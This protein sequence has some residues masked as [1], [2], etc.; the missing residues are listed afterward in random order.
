MDLRTTTIDIGTTRPLIL[1]HS[2]DAAELS[3]HPLDRVRIRGQRG[4]T[5]GIVKLT[6]ELVD[7]GEVGLTDPLHHLHGEVSVTLA[8]TPRSVQ[9]ITAKLA[10]VELDRAELEAIVQDIHE[11]RLSD[12]ELGAYV[13]AIAAN[14]LSLQETKHLTEAMSAVGKQL[15]WD[16]PI[17]ADKHSIGGVAGN[18][19]TPIVVS[20]VTAAGVTMPKTSSR[21]VTSPAGTADVMEVFCD[22]EFSLDEIVDI[23]EETNGCLVWG[24][25]VDLSPVDDEIIRAEHPL[26]LDPVGQLLASVLSKKQSAG[27]THV[28][29]DI[30]YG[31][32]AKVESLTA[33]RELADDFKRVGEYL[34][35]EI[36]AALTQGS[37]PVGLGIGPALEARDVLRVL[38]GDGPSD[39]RHKSV[40]L[41]AML[42]DHCGVDADARHLLESGAALEQFRQ[43]VTVQNGDPDISAA[44]IEPGGETAIVEADRDGFVTRIDNRLVCDIAR[45]AGAPKDQ[46]AGIVIHT[47]VNESITAGDELLTIHAEAASKL[48]EAVSVANR[49]EPVRIRGAGQAVIERR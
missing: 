17:V 32:D 19:T 29:I 30:P 26:S 12:I 43:L 5:T 18:C 21:A 33:G 34:D 6:D 49:S 38:E 41:A 2:T 14:G 10:D 45:R 11:N 37:E 9:H 28:A 20:I 35:M 39:L 1:L 42:L 3:A 24:G 23:V 40:Q 22:V 15:S 36:C 16:T 47:S 31:E 8:G 25:G 46:R 48:D 44:D 13:S 4:T 7:P 27:S